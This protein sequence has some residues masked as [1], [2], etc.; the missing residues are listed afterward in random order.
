M[1]EHWQTGL[2]TRNT[3]WLLEAVPQNFLELSR[4]LAAEKGIKNGDTAQGLLRAR[5]GHVQGRS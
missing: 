5:R 3:P 1:T 4:E 2:M